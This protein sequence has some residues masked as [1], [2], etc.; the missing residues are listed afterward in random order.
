MK[1]DGSQD[2]RKW[3][4]ESGYDDCAIIQAGLTQ[5]NAAGVCPSPGHCE[6][7]LQGLSQTAAAPASSASRS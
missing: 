6:A 7:D 2:R 5:V 3:T 1:T 4:V